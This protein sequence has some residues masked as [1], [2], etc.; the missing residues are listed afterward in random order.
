[1]SHATAMFRRHLTPEVHT[2][3]K[4]LKTKNGFTID[5]VIRSGVDNPDSSIGAYA[6]D[7]ESYVLFGPV[8]GKIVEEYHGHGSDAVHVSDMDMEALA[9]LGNPDPEG[10]SVISTRIRVGRNLSGFP[11]QPAISR[12]ERLEVERKVVEALNQLDGDLS[13]EYYSLVGMEEE[14]RA[15]LVADHFLFK[16]GDDINIF[17]NARGPVDPSCLKFQP[18]GLNPY[19]RCV[20]KRNETYNR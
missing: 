10:A 16:Q 15:Q 3:L 1:M 9:D 6:G 12:A 5:D 11:F 18:E 8:L 17:G 14:V 19:G 13:G 7:E 2:T 4:G 20:G